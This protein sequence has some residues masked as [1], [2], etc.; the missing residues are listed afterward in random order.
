MYS[1]LDLTIH[2]FSCAR[3]DAFSVVTINIAVFSDIMMFTV[4]DCY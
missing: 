3:S 4:I 1:K 2:L